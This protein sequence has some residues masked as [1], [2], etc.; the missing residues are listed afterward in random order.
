MLSMDIVFTQILIILLYVLIGFAAG[1]YG[2][3]DPDQRKYLTRICTD[4]IMPFTVLSAS[5]QDLTGSEIASLGLV[6][7]ILIT[8]YILVTSAAL[9]L[10]KLRRVPDPVR[11]T[12]ASLVTYPNC[13]FLGLP[14]C[15][16]L[17]GDKAILY[18]SV[19]LIAFNVLFFT[20]Q[21]T[22]FTGRKFNIRNLITLPTIATVIL[23]GML[24]LHLHFPSPVQTVIN[25]T[26]AIISPLSLIIIGVMLSENRISA[27]LKEKQAYL[28]TMIRNLLI[29]VLYLFLLRFLP[30]SAE[31]KLCLLVY[32]SCPSATLTTIY[33]IQN[34]MAPEYAAHSVL[35]ST[36]FFAA[37]LPVII[38]LGT[39][40]LY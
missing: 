28:T 10:Q 9:F 5:D 37:T 22:M 4:L 11:I 3:V 32:M 15:Y 2:L 8:L 29:P 40:F 13:T 7:V 6:F 24:L 21:Y 33:A 39:A 26:G 31:D 19:A 38:Y 16:A 18:N 17:F 1:K 27:I 12:T 34:D 30:F 20:W 35:M 36:I 14:L 23:I 25:N